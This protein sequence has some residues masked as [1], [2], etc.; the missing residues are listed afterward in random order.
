MATRIVHAV[1]TFASRGS[2]PQTLI[3]PIEGRASVF[4]GGG[5]NS[6]WR[7]QTDGVTSYG[8]PLPECGLTLEVTGAPRRCPRPRRHVPARPVDRKVRLH[9]HLG[10]NAKLYAEALQHL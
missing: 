8:F 10:R 7:Q 4:P 3:L 2:A 5:V 9:R 1:F 6:G